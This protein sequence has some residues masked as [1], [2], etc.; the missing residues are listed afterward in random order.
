M[1]HNKTTD[2]ITDLFAKIKH[3]HVIKS[4]R[5][6]Y[7]CKECKAFGATLEILNTKVCHKELV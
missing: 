6:G 4:A 5:F 3:K 1:V 2:V 7:L